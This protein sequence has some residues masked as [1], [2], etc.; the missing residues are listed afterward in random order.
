[1]VFEFSKFRWGQSNLRQ[2]IL[3]ILAPV[4]R[5][6]ALP[7]CFSRSGRRRAALNSKASARQ[8]IWPGLDSEFYRLEQK[9]AERGIIRNSSEPLSAWL[10]RAAAE[11]ACFNLREPLARILSLHYRY[12]F[13]PAGLSRREDRAELSRK[14]ARCLS[15]LA[16]QK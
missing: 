11:P 3:W 1:M 9:L 2:Y 8:I 4:L 16:P 10:R 5:I 13:D 6:A 14:A 12:R 15:Q 7:N